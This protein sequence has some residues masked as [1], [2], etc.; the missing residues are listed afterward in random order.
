MMYT[1]LRQAISCLEADPK[2]TAKWQNRRCEAAVPKSICSVLLPCTHHGLLPSAPTLIQALAVAQAPEERAMQCSTTWK[3]KEQASA[4]EFAMVLHDRLENHECQ[5]ATQ[6]ERGDGQVLCER[7]STCTQSVS[8][9][10]YHHCRG[11]SHLFR[12]EEL[13]RFGYSQVV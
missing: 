11:I 13:P 5:S 9:N 6:H 4:G 3:L 2:T 10:L 12:N 8:Q 1:V 7:P